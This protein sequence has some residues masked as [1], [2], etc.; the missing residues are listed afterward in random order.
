MN[1]ATQ[2]GVGLD[3]KPGTLA[4]LCGALRRA[5]VDIQAVSVTHDL[6]SCWVRL[7]ATPVAAARAAL[8]EG[9]Y[10]FSTQKVLLLSVKH[11]PGVL[12]QIASK[13]GRA[14]ININYVY[15][16]NAGASGT[17]VLRVS[18]PVRAAEVL[19]E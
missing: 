16:S 15:G 1:K 17:L 8:T 18:D 11:E 12:E 10:H 6:E 13:L 19:G 3:N 9:G 14:R 4:K 2:F 5:G 7:V